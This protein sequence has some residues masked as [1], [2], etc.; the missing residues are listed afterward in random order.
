M[1]GAEV[2]A[3]FA[4][5]DLEGGEPFAHAELGGV[6]IMMG[7]LV[8]RLQEGGVN[9]DA[10]AGFQNAEDFRGGGFRIAQ[11]FEDV[12]RDDVV[13]GVV[14]ERQAVRVADDIGVAKDFV[15]ELD[16]IRETHGAAA[17]AEVEAEF[18]FLA[19]HGFED[20]RRLRC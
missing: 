5:F 11:M 7:R 3:H 9:R 17:G 1:P 6:V 10:A 16:A 18:V 13:E 14:A 20:R 2:A 19:Q 4:R 12:E 15:L 8:Q